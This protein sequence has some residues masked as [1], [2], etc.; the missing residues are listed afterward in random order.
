MTAQEHTTLRAVFVQAQP[1]D[2][3]VAPDPAFR[4]LSDMGHKV[5]SAESTDDAM[6]MLRSRGP[7][8]LMVVDASGLPDATRL[9]AQ[10]MD[11]PP[12][13]RPR[14]VAIFSDRADDALRALRRRASPPNVHVFLKPLH[15]HGLLGVLRNLEADAPM[16]ATA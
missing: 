15:L 13:A 3:G 5:A 14:Q 16:E 10:L 12:G 7:T 1:A 4:L 6:A 2:A 11:L 8:D 9:A